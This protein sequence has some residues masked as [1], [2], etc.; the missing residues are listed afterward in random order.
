MSADCGSETFA[1]ISQENDP[2]SKFSGTAGRVQVSKDEKGKY[3]KDKTFVRVGFYDARQRPALL[4]FP[5]DKC[6]LMPMRFYWNPEED[7]GTEYN[8]EDL[9]LQ[10]FNGLTKTKAVQL[11]PGYAATLYQG[12]NW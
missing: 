4:I 6:E 1:N 5:D 9:I 10:D 2:K 12:K 7:N 8:E 3:D 11:P